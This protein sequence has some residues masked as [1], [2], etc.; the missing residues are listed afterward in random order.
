MISI[1]VI[2]KEEPELDA[3]LSGVGAQAAALD[4]EVELVVVDASRGR[5]AAI[6]DRHPAVRWHDFIPP[7][8]VGISIPHQ[9]NA[10]VRCARGDIVV[11]TDAGCVPRDGW[12]YRLVEPILAGRERFTAGIAPSP[13]GREG[14]YDEGMVNARGGDYLEE[15]ATINIAFE[16]EVF[17]RVGGFDET[18]QYGSD[19]DFSWRARDAGVAIR[20][21]PGA[22]VEHDWGSDGRQLRRGYLYGRARARLYR[23]HPR[24]LPGAW[25]TDP[26]AIAYPLFLLGLPLTLRHPAYPA[27]LAIPAWRNRRTGA[28]RAVGDHLAYGVGVLR[29]LA[30]S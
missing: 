12:L 8:G 22:V 20:S 11:F 29:E 27:L 6:S 30:P 13:G 15:T 2:S 24:R 14:T 5:L 4:H 19:I 17:D 21:M 18:F 7:N 9:R 26:V 25:R 16:R 3:T 10:G 23:K 1:V 28:A